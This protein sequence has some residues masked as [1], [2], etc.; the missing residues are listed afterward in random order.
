MPSIPHNRIK[1]A[2]VITRLDWGGSPDIVRII[3]T[4]LDPAVYD[5]RLIMGETLH[6]CARTQAFLMDFTGR[7]KIV[8]HL[9]REIDL[10]H[11]L[12]AFMQLYFLFRRERFDIVH[13]HTAKA[14][15]LAR[16]AAFL[17]GQ[18]VIVHT[19]HGHNFYGYFSKAV[20][21]GIVLVEKFLSCFTDRIIALTELEKRDLI[22]YGVASADKVTV[23]YQGL[24]L[25]R[26]AGASS[27]TGALR[28]AFGI[29]RDER[30][31]GMVGRLEP[32]KGP[33]YFIEAAAEIAAKNSRIKFIIAGEGSLKEKLQNRVLEL[34]IK[35]KVI[36]LGWREDVPEII[37]LLD[38]LVLPSLNEAVGM[39]LLEAG[40]AGVA[41]VATKVGGVP[42]MVHD[43][44]T[45]ILVPAHNPAS[46]AGAV[47]D[48]LADPRKRLE[49][50][51]AAQAWVQ[52][53]FKA[54]DMAGNLSILYQELLKKK[55]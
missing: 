16:M 11:D 30:V 37:S 25:S 13:T 52:G 42:E 55:A 40:A 22:T 17:S 14:G 34:G 1:V 31:I 53:R 39:V 4:H 29:G 10:M 8:P 5:V 47:N 27:N 24:E 12:R 38:V 18:P 9:K 46:L 15:A 23:I 43:N 49:M 28:D 19:P 20:S 44:Q 51:K 2:H 26:Y 45:G 7:I 50:G 32:I 54:E 21:Y 41:V 33:E 48:L 3:C 36:F 6:P 35:D